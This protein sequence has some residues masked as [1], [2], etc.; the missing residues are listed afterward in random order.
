[1]TNTIIVG[2][3]WG[4]EGKGKIVDCLHSSENYK[5]GVR[6][7]GA[8]NAGHTV[9]IEDKTYKLHGVPTSILHDDCY[10]VIGNG[11][12]VSLKSNGDL[13]GLI[14]ELEDLEKTDSIRGSLIISNEAHLIMPWHLEIDGKDTKIGT[15]KRGI[16]PAYQDKM[17]RTEAIRMQDLKDPDYFYQKLVEIKKSHE[18]DPCYDFD[19]DNVAKEYLDLFSRISDVVIG[20]S[21]FLDERLSEGYSILF[22]GAQGTFLDVDHGTYPFVTSSN[23]TAGGAVTGSGVGPTKINK[24]IGVSKA[25]TTRVGSGPFQTEM[26][27][28]LSLAFAELAKEYGTTTGR[29]RRC[30]WL[31]IPMQRFAKRVNGLSSL[32]ITKL[33]ILDKLNE[34]GLKEIPICTHY[35][36]KG[37][38]MREFPEGDT[39]VLEKVTPHYEYAETWSESTSGL[40]EYNKL[41]QRA[42][43][44]LDLISDLV[45][46]PIEIIST[47]PTRKDTIKL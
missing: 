47:G 30:G 17:G 7:Q 39:R 29:T 13:K 28:E 44:Y 16:G 41:P 20:T 10:A 36:Y 11:C 37:K 33:D 45:E 26:P 6:Y 5:V 1:M 38:P 46:I 2:A 40:Q 3:Q 4:D 22:E 31:D 35:I 18:N 23:P 42:K 8:N 14:K 9:C 15:T 27:K 25:Y 32:A 12:L 34:L 19:P 24:V 21:T 43:D